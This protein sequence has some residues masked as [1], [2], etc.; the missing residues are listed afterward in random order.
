MLQELVDGALTALGFACNRPVT[1]VLRVASDLEPV[2][3]PDGE[4]SAVFKVRFCRASLRP[5]SY[6]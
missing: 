3:V 6:R 4:G 1:V 2:G 5:C